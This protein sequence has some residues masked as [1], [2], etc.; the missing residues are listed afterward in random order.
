[1]PHRP[2]ADSGTGYQ[3]GMDL[4]WR[5][6]AGAM[7]GPG[8]FGVLDLGLRSGPWSAEL[9]T[10]T[11]DLR[12]QPS[13]DRGRAWVGGRAAAW[14]A[15]FLPFRWRDG[16]RD[17]GN[18]LGA[19]YVGPDAGFVR[20]GPGGTWAGA[21]AAVR[22]WSFFPLAATTR[23]VPGLT[24]VTTADLAAGWWREWGH[25]EVHL[26]FD[27]RPAAWSPHLR[28]ELALCAPGP[29]S[30]LVELRGQ[31]AAGTDELTALRLGGTSPY[32]L[33]LAGLA[34]AEHHVEDV[35]A[36]RT[37][38]VAR[39][40]GVEASGFV[41]TATFGGDDGPTEVAGLGAS[42]VA[43]RGTAFAETSAGV[44]PWT[45]RPTGAAWGAWLRFGTT[46]R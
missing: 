25:A 14:S 29:V 20:Y 17:P 11:L 2:G 23:E 30:P 1:M 4:E 18:E 42:V 36:A 32:V 12:W 16:A 31:W 39:A 35:F 45:E 43:R 3:G 37:G 21:S 6:D 15:G 26:G 41:D 5:A 9:Y 8:A 38:A 33:P 19:R 10:D 34:V 27:A 44:A 28:G 24:S 22:A 7:V 46:W 13:S 40:A